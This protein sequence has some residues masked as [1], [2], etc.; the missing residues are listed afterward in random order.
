[1]SISNFLLVMCYAI[2]TM[3]FLILITF[4][5]WFVCIDYI[6]NSVTYTGIIK[7]FVKKKN[8]NIATSKIIDNNII[9]RLINK[10]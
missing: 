3:H 9:L 2:D 5:I 8:I 1:M 10:K 4:P 7:S 6:Q